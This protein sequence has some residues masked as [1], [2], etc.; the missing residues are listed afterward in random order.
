MNRRLSLAFVANIS[1][2][3]LTKPKE[4]QFIKDKRELIKG[5]LHMLFFILKLKIYNFYLKT[6]VHATTTYPI[7][8]TI[9]FL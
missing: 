9:S 3:T 1:V 6:I 2:L 8:D 5:V 4:K 7:L